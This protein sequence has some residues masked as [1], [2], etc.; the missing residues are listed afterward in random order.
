MATKTKNR[1]ESNGHFEEQVPGGELVGG[2]QEAMPTSIVIPKIS[3]N[4]MQ[5]E[6][7]GTSPLLVH[8]WDVKSIEMIARKQQKKAQTAKE[9]RNPEAEFDASRYISTDK[10]DGV[11]SSGL[12]AALVAACRVVDGLPM[13]MAKRMLF[14]KSDGRTDKGLGL[15]RIISGDPKMDTQM[16]RIAQGTSDI[17]YRARYDTW[18]M[19]LRIEFL[20][21]TISAEQV[22][23][24]L[25]TAGY[26][27]GL[28]EYRPGAPKS[29]N[30]ENGRFRIKR[31]D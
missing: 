9:A 8:A 6:I 19:I 21:N 25:E 24:L 3:V 18:S 13:T 1:I 23:N 31:S 11:P 12:K 7:V 28:C 5:V 17:R 22:V 30:G 27:E 16:V 2:K 14:V 26:S 29:L 15:C 4:E 10:W 20:A